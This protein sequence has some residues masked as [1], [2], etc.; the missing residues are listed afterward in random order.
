MQ[1]TYSI[2]NYNLLCQLMFAT[3]I[4]CYI[5]PQKSWALPT[6][7][8]ILGLLIRRIK[9]ILNSPI[10]TGEGMVVGWVSSPCSGYEGA[11]QLRS[12]FVAAAGGDIRDV[13]MSPASAVQPS[14]AGF[15]RQQTSVAQ[16]SEVENPGKRRKIPRVTASGRVRVARH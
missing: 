5:N 14:A 16:N 10:L 3:R 4:T 6:L 8:S 12:P 13:W 9:R 1:C 11:A 7:L 2:M 15:S